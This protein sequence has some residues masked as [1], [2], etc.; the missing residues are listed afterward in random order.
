MSRPL[1]IRLLAGLLLCLVV[2]PAV[3]ASR[4][5]EV[6]QQAEAGISRSPVEYH[7]ADGVP[8]GPKPT[9]DGGAGNSR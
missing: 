8:P 3:Y 2:G 9:I 6:P 5:V 7:V 4:S 1:L